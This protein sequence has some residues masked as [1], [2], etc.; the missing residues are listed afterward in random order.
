[1][2]GCGRHGIDDDDEML[3]FVLFVCLFAGSSSRD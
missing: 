3:G 2:C 1:M